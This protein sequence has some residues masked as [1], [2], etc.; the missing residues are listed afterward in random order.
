[1]LNPTFCEPIKFCVDVEEFERP[2]FHC[3]IGL[4]V[5]WLT[6]ADLHVLFWVCDALKFHCMEIGGNCFVCCYISLHDFFVTTEP[7]R[8]KYDIKKLGGAFFD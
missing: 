8:V 7:E 4:C 6:S 2:S 3:W 5:I 1:M